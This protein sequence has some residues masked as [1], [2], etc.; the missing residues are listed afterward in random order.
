MTLFYHFISVYTDCTM[1][2]SLPCQHTNY[3]S[4]HHNFFYFLP[5]RELCHGMYVP[6][7]QT[8]ILTI[9]FSRL[10]ADHSNVKKNLCPIFGPIFGSNNEEVLPAISQWAL[11]HFAQIHVSSDL[12]TLPSSLAS[13]FGTRSGFHGSFSKGPQR[14]PCAVKNKNMFSKCRNIIMDFVCILNISWA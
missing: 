7:V 4:G 10:P 13:L 9:S 3:Y 12:I 11:F 2:L 6:K 1:W 14:F 5:T 8:R